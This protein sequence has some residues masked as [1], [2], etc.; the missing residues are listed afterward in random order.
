MDKDNKTKYQG[1]VVEES[2]ADNRIINSLEITKVT[3]TEEDNPAER[4]HIYKVLVTKDDI[5]RLSQ[6]IKPGW[7]M[8]FWQGREVIAIFSGIQFEFNY[9]DKA[10]WQPAIDHGL[11][12]GIPL[13]Q[14]DFIIE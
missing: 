1:A 5:E 7:Y 12:V 6:D 9:D 13:E 3:V 8:H 2:L 14:L 11:S 10:S 4:W